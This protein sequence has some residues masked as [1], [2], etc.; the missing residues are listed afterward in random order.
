MAIILNGKKFYTTFLCF[1]IR[2]NSRYFVVN[3]KP[4]KNQKDDTITSL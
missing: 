1:F 4:N 2:A 3:K